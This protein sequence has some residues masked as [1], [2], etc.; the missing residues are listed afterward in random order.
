MY[1]SLCRCVHMHSCTMRRPEVNVGY[2][3]QLFSALFLRQD[4]SLKPELTGLATVAGQGQCT[5]A[6][7]VPGLQAH[8]STFIQGLG[9][10]SW[11]HGKCFTKRAI[12]L[13]DE[14]FFLKTF[15]QG[16][17]MSPTQPSLMTLKI[18]V[19][20]R[21]WLDSSVLSLILFFFFFFL[22]VMN[23]AVPRF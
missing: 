10:S 6:S 20:M 18:P 16:P 3:S 8:S 7:L 14:S 15:L 13:A 11:S 2:L 21:G 23:P 19:L 9:T 4:L 17:H 5:S 1:T 12:S 22:M